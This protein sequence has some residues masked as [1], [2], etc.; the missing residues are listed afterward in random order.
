VGSLHV[1]DLEPHV[2]ERVRGESLFL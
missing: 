2:A 1:P